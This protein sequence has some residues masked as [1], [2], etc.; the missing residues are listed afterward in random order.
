MLN[1]GPLLWPHPDPRGHHL[2][3]LE[4]TL[5]QGVFTQVWW[6][7]A[8]W[9]LRRRFFKTP[10]QFLMFVNYLPL[11]KGVALH[12]NNFESFSPKDD[13]YQL[14]L[15][16]AQCF[17]RRSRKCKSLTDR[18]TD[19]LTDRQTTDNRRSEK[20]TWAFGSGELKINSIH[21]RWTDTKHLNKYSSGI[22]WYITLTML[23]FMHLKFL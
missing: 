5:Y 15:K 18:W 14:W 13:L 7:L 17:W 2:N 6:F 11:Y 9:F 1:F 3:K 23:T 21:S 22:Q 19:G 20:L 12:L 16:L 10:T 4:S 8:P